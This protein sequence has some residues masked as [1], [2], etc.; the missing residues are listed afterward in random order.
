MNILDQLMHHLRETGKCNI[1][2]CRRWDLLNRIVLDHKPVP[3]ATLDHSR[4]LL[5]VARLR[6][7]ENDEH[8]A[9]VYLYHAAHNMG[10][11]E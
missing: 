7:V 6:I 2:S 1:T 10:L 5:E 9:R 3:D 4:V 11:I 8:T